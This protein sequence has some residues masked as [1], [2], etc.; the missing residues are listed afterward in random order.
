MTNTATRAAYQ[1]VKADL[2]AIVAEAASLRDAGHG[3]VVT[4]SPKVFI[5]L[6]HLCRDVCHYCTFA[7][8]PR[9][10]SKAFL[11]PDEVLDIVR[12]GAGAGCTEALFTLG[13][14]PET[15][16]AAARTAL[17]ALGHRSTLSYL[18]EVARRVH[19]ETG[20]LPHLNPGVMSR[21]ELA[22]LRPVAA[23]MGLMVE[24]T[25]DRLGARG[26]PHFGSP[27]KEPQRRLE[28]LRLA[29]EA[30][31]PFT[32]GL[33]IGIGE[34]R[35][36]RI[37]T[38]LAIKAVHERYGHIQ[39]VI[40]QNFRA[41]PG[42]RMAGAPEPSFDELRWTIAAARLLL[43]PDMNIQAPPNLSDPD[44]L[45]DLIRA[46]INDWG[47]VSPVTADHVNPERRW[48]SRERLA[49]AT[50][51]AG[52][53]LVGRLPVY[54][55][56]ARHAD[57]WLDPN[58]R[59]AVVRQSDSNGFARDDRWMAGSGVAIGGRLSFKAE[60]AARTR[61]LVHAIETGESLGEAEIHR[62]L[63]SRDGDLEY[64]K[65]ASD[66]ARQASKGDVVTYVVNRNIN[67]TN[68][69]AYRCRFC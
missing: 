19:E 61:D 41:K 67:Y 10:L 28:V 64:V 7:K 42:T 56:F 37:D 39:E 38:L 27:D 29:G 31:I 54:P 51:R 17:A 58:M 47:G 46:G 68:I 26:G 20:L 30:Q 3:S 15:R 69:C 6:T 57:R 45:H 13:D 55:E 43:G 59:R 48:P 62:L 23:S 25:A 24:T 1:L 34:T 66:R 33:L 44:A 11:E 14:R 53:I 2:E 21:D 35:H 9:Q 63:D 32:T 16:Y 36:E 4:F 12:A 52:K 50:A 65:E 49:E 40:I 60:P 8:A 22:E 5:P 18:V